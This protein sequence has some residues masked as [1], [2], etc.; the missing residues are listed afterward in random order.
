MC[1][2]FAYNSRISITIYLCT[3]FLKLERYTKLLLGMVSGTENYLIRNRYTKRYM[4]KESIGIEA[5]GL[6][7]T[8]FS[9]FFSILFK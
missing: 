6:F 8:I 4:K 5:Y 9:L 3:R 1:K 7:Y 2:L